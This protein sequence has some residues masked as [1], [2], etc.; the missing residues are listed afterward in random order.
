MNHRQPSDIS[1]GD[2]S[3]LPRIRAS[4]G[5]TDRVL[6]ALESRGRENSWSHTRLAWVGAAVL[7]LA[8]LIG[9][10]FIY[11]RQRAAD[12]A[13]QHQLEELR[14]RYEQ[15]LDEV[16]AIRQEAATPNTRL[17]LG[18]DESLDLMLDLIQLSS[19]SQNGRQERGE[20]RPASWE[21]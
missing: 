18:G 11:Q 4:E 15:L 16:V 8:V 9:S 1:T 6:T 12:L 19:Y 10:G 7:A 17:Y 20:V 21:K 3:R 2:L 13:Y 5:F 14:S